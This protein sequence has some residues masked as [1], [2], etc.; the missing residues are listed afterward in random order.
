MRFLPLNHR[1][2]IVELNS[3]DETLALHR[4]LQAAPLP[5]I[6]EMIPAART[7]MISFAPEIT[8]AQSLTWRSS[9]GSSS[10]S[11]VHRAVARPRCCG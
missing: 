2:F 11:S 7:L 5:G 8:T 9:A 1:N 4:A 6:E 3:L 10:S